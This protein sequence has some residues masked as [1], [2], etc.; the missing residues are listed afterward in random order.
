MLILTRDEAGRRLGKALEPY[1]G[2]EPLVVL[3]LS[4]GGMRVGAEIAAHFAAPLDILPATQLDVPGRLHSTF[5]AIVD[6]TVRIDTR[7]VVELGLPAAYVNAMV[8]IGRE[9][10]D[11]EARALRGHSPPA[12]VRGHTAVLA[13]DGGA[14]TLLATT[15]VQALREDGALRVL[16][17]APVTHPE[18][19]LH[20]PEYVDRYV[21]L[22]DPD[23][24][25]APLVRDTAF[26]QT[27]R[28]D[29]RSLVRHS[30]AE[31]A[32]RERG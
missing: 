22:C 32:V 5:G 20:L 19:A 13:D 11:A 1:V 9:K 18:L 28:F 17:A 15:A 21:L 23:P 27:T 30:R 26:E 6:G 2:R 10:A 8:R 16:F 12:L 4:V 14:T 31:G 7:R 24:A 25:S 29:V 3:G